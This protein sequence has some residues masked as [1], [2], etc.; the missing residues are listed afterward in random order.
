[1]LGFGKDVDHE[2]VNH[3]L[4]P[5]FDLVDKCELSKLFKEETMTKER[6]QFR[7][8]VLLFMYKS[9]IQN[10]LFK[11]SKELKNYEFQS[12]IKYKFEQ[13]RKDF[14]QPQKLGTNV[15]FRSRNLKRKK[16]SDFFV[17]FCDLQD[18]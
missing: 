18:F 7:R 13:V 12:K 16:R 2:A 6:K 17:V 10:C 11:N 1:M 3:M 8:S 15:H 5:L 14:Y 4:P 9:F